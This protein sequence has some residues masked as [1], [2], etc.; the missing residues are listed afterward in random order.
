M[1]DTATKAAIFFRSET[2][3]VEQ[4]K[5]R[6]FDEHKNCFRTCRDRIERVGSLLH[7]LAHEH[8][9]NATEACLQALREA[10]PNYCSEWEEPIAENLSYWMSNYRQFRNGM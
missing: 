5:E 9:G 6:L 8:N 10:E 2:E 3:T 4:A 1:L 7:K